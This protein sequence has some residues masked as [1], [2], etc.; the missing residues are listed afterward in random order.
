MERESYR[1]ITVQELVDEVK[2]DT[3][4]FPLGMNTVIVSGDFEG[5]Y[6]HQKHEL[7]HECG[8]TCLAYEMHEGQN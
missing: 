7:Q 4:H 2:F 6:T 5:N 3:L 8:K 1:C